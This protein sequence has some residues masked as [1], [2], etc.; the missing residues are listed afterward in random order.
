MALLK[1]SIR[2]KTLLFLL[3]SLA[4][5][6]CCSLIFLFLSTV[7]SGGGV[8]HVL[9]VAESPK[10][11]LEDFFYFVDCGLSLN[12]L[13]GEWIRVYLFTCLT[14]EVYVYVSQVDSRISCTSSA[15]GTK[16]SSQQIWVGSWWWIPG[17]P[18]NIVALRCLKITMRGAPPVDKTLM[19]KS[20]IC[21][22]SFLTIYICWTH[23]KKRV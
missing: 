10:E 5:P 6:S 21:R 11:D 22:V 1:L 19:I 4:L 16:C 9:L 8:W 23:D 14:I 13:S 18:F 2:S 7:C 17:Q 15:V 3:S 12:D 20:V